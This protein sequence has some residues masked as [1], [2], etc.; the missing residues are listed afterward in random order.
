[1]P[2]RQRKLNFTQHA[3]RNEWA[4]VD[5]ALGDE[6]RHVNCVSVKARKKLVSRQQQGRHHNGAH[7]SEKQETV[8]TAKAVPQPI[9]AAYEQADKK[10]RR[11]GDGSESKEGNDRDLPESA[12]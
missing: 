9:V 11:N 8:V 3:R 5:E 1:M 10:A 7:V 2:K 12:K 4:T 6:L